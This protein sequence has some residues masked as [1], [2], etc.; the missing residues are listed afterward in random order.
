MSIDDLCDMIAE[1]IR[2]LY[3]HVG[4]GEDDIEEKFIYENAEEDDPAKEDGGEAPAEDGNGATTDPDNA[5]GDPET[6]TED[7]EQNTDPDVPEG[8]TNQSKS[9]EPAEQNDEA[10]AEEDDPVPIAFE[11]V[12]R[13]DEQLWVVLTAALA[14]FQKVQSQYDGLTSY[15]TDAMAVTHGDAPF[16]NLQTKIDGLKGE[17]DVVWWRMVRYNML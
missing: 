7:V 1:A 13:P 5:E 16:K 12:L 2:E 14:F 17:R 4:K 9:D 11:D 15:T 3:V 8:P 6:D 10:N